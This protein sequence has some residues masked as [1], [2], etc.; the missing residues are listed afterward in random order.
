MKN[1][2]ALKVLGV[3]ALLAIA[4][5]SALAQGGGTLRIAYAAIQQLDPYKTASNDEIHAFSQVFDPLFILSREDFSPV[6]HAAT[7]WENPDDLTWV[8][9]LREGVY[10]Q[11]GNDVFAE[12]EAREVTAEDWVYSI[13]RFINESTA[14]AMGDIESVE[15]LDRYT[16][17]ITTPEPDPFLMD[18]NRLA[19]VVAIPHE[20]IEVLGEDGFAQRPFGSGPFKLTDFRPNQS[21]RFERNEDYWLPVQLDAVEF[22][23]IPDPTVQTIALE[24]DEIDVIPY[25]LNIDEADWLMENPDVELHGRGGS[26]RGLGFNLS[27]APFDEFEVRD[28]I[29]MAMDIDSAVAA[30]VEPFGFRA[31]G[32]VP[33]WTG[34]ALDPELESYWTYDPEAA[35]AQLESV[36]F[37]KNA[38]GIYERDGVPLSFSVKVVAGSPVRVLTILVTQLQA[39]GINAE[40][41]LQDTAV[42]ADDLVAGNNTGLFFDFSY[43]GVTGLWSLFH[44][45]NIGMSNTHFYSNPEVDAIFDEASYT[46]DF[47]ARQELWHQAQRLIMADRAAI[48][49][50]FENGFSVVSSSVVDWVGPWAGLNLVTLENSTYKED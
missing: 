26:W 13:N 12:G 11:D 9:H 49:L 43:A 29:S 41:L 15:A 45:S 38:N 6:P 30:V 34:F 31:Y 2:S 21:L 39:F 37:A 10:F 16:L 1:T 44:S 28:A 40:L 23:F 3:T 35:A 4:A 20:A 5:S 18:G 48:P 22:V 46:V 27:T 8:F 47:E 7:S 14:F 25:L 36:G 32:Q 17:Q 42:W 50:Y 33:D 19:R 24:A